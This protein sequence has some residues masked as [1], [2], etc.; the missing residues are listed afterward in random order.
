MQ[1]WSVLHVGCWKYRT[2][3]WRKNRHL[4]TITQLCRAV[5][6]QLRHVSTIGKEL[7]KRQYLLYMSSQYAELP[8]IN[9]WDL[10]ASLGHPA[11]FNGFRLLAALLQRRCLTEANQTLHDVWL[12][13]GLLHYIYIFGGSCP[14]QNVDRCKI[15][16]TSKSC[17]LLYWLHYCTALQQQAS[18]KLCGVQQRASSIS[19]RA[20]I[21][22]GIGPHSSSCNKHAA[23]H[24]FHS[25]LRS[26]L[27]CFYAV[28]WAAGR[29]SGL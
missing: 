21:T 1:F 24:D 7:V 15:Q 17:V 2:Q 6:S 16:F 3:K 12:F 26:C 22:L 13:P 5:S 23:L 20:A 14:Q 10:L 9:G 8:P 18:A 19:G 25:Q 11:N 29:A 28:G 27:Q 4:R